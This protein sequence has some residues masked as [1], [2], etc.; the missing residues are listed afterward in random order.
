MRG[1]TGD[2]RLGFGLSQG[3]V[4]HC[5]EFSHILKNLVFGCMRALVMGRE[6]MMVI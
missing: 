1:C 6:M 4:I 2:L 5:T 3:R